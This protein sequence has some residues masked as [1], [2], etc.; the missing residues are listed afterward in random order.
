MAP[1]MWKGLEL[2]IASDKTLG[3]FRLRLL[4]ILNCIAKSNWTSLRQWMKPEESCCSM[5]SGVTNWGGAM[6][7]RGRVLAPIDIVTIQIL[8]SP[9]QLT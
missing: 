2:P 6:Q 8:F 7:Y 4:L 3:L 5:T 9:S 1:A